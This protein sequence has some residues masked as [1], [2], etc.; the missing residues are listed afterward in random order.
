MKMIFGEIP[1]TA[2]MGPKVRETYLLDQYLR[3]LKNAVAQTGK[4]PRL[5]YVKI[6]DPLKNRT[7]YDLVYLTR[8]PLGITVFME[9]SEKLDLIQKRIRTKV[10]KQYRIEKSGQ[11]EFKFESDTNIAE[12]RVDLDAV[13][14]YWLSKLSYEPKQFGIE[15]LADMHE[16]TGWFK[17]DFQ[18]AFNELLSEGKVINIDAPK[19]RPVHAVHFEKGEYLKKM[20]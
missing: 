5:A 7:K 17:G 11:Y 18:R 3:A 1:N 10:Q 8:H 4:K 9:E 14:D 16:E 12:D 2:G 6:L 13:K 15:Q 19:K 20:K